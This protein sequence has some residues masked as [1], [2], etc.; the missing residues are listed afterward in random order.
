[1]LQ[2]VA[3]IMVLNNVSDFMK[4]RSLHNWICEDS[5]FMTTFRGLVQ[6]PCGKFNIIMTLIF[7]PPPP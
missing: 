5:M 3:L 7:L 4:A 6:N 1:M 2:W